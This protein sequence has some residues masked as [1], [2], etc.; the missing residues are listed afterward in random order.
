MGLCLLSSVSKDVPDP[1]T[2]LSRSLDPPRPI[3]VREAVN[4][5]K[6]IGA[7]LETSGQNSKLQPTDYGTLLATLPFA[8][9]DSRTIL[10]AAQHGFLYEML[11]LRSILTIRPYP[12]V[13]YFGDESANV[14]AQTMYHEDVNVKTLCRFRADVPFMFGTSNGIPVEDAAHKKQFPVSL[15]QLDPTLRAA[16]YQKR[17]V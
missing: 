13:H 7:C 10:K 17:F 4:Y 8:I 11:L 12:I 6:G 16:T 3:V 2:L 1:I 5:L 9:T 14:S 15:E